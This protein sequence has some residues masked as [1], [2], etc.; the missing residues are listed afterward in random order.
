MDDMIV[1]NNN[2]HSVYVL[3]SNYR[4]YGNFSRHNLLGTSDGTNKNSS[5]CQHSS[6]ARSG[7][8]SCSASSLTFEHKLCNLGNFCD[9]PEAIGIP[10]TTAPPSL[11]ATV[12]TTTIAPPPTRC[13]PPT[14][15]I[16]KFFNCSYVSAAG[17][18][19]G[20]H[21]LL[22]GSS[23]GDGCGGAV[24]VLSVQ[25]TCQI[26]T[27]SSNNKKKSVNLKPSLIAKKTK[28]RKFIE[29]EKWRANE[30]CTGE[31]EFL[32]SGDNACLDC[33]GPRT[34]IEFHTNSC[35]KESNAAESTMLTASM[36]AMASC[37]SYNTTV[38]HDWNGKLDESAAGS[39]SKRH[40]EQ[41][42][43]SYW[44]GNGDSSHQQKHAQP[45]LEVW[46]LSQQQKSNYDLYKEATELL[47]LSCTLC[48]NCRCLECQSSYFDCDDSDSLSD[49]SNSE[50]FDEE[51]MNAI[52][53]SVD[54]VMYAHCYS[55]KAMTNNGLSTTQSEQH[56]KIADQSQRQ[57]QQTHHI[58]HAVNCNATDLLD[59]GYDSCKLAVDDEVHATERHPPNEIENFMS[60]NELSLSDID[61]EASSGT[62]KERRG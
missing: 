27:S 19:N 56:W 38:K 58:N 40:Q 61:V 29:E 44:S 53:N 25:R 37:E 39:G 1:Q 7:N 57:T 54:L 51:T 17:E 31:N 35:V 60:F 49:L 13:L 43:S 20:V 16:Q 4:Y 26:K 12:P 9:V 59:S 52:N 2:Q 23:R 28:F 5:N 6:A 11:S 50:E 10:V 48:D 18:G 45:Q 41:K 32:H 3:N 62:E 22:A 36:A 46:K 33:T 14:T 15:A 47:G 30:E 21:A 34:P 8:R 55:D 42:Q 24:E